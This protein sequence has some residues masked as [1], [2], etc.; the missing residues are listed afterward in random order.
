MSE[1]I[2]KPWVQCYF[3]PMSHPSLEN[4]DRE[5]ERET[6]LNLVTSNLFLYEADRFRYSKYYIC[7][8]GIS[9]LRRERERE[10][11]RSVTSSLTAS[12]ASRNISYNYAKLLFCGFP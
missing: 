3:S 11:E 6:M 2:S 1:R 4:R 9:E 12:G 8:A 7:S 5:K 10:R